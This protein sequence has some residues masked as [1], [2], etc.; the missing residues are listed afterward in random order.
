M[1]FAGYKAAKRSEFPFKEI[2]TN[3]RY[4]QKESIDIAMGCYF[5]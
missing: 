1:I 5:K 3:K 4:S 2:I